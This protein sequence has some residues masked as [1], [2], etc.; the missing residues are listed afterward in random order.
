[1]PREYPKV[2]WNGRIIGKHRAVMQA[3]IGR[4]LRPGE[5]VHHIDNDPRNNDISN[6]LI[7][8]PREHAAIHR[9]GGRVTLV[10]PACGGKFSRER[11]RVKGRK[12]PPS[13]SRRCAG[14]ERRPER[15]CEKCGETFTPRRSTTRFCCR[16]CASDARWGR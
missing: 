10:C 3:H 14:Q 11:N 2:K 9:P 5:Q 12:K 13:C 8:T 1:M 15:S 7:V 16:Q 6:L 4:E